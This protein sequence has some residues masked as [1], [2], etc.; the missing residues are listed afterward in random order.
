LV[1]QLVWGLSWSVHVTGGALVLA[2]V[3]GLGLSFLAVPPAD[4]PRAA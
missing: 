2:G 1:V 4:P 3:S